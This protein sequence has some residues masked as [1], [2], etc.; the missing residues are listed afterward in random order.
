MPPSRKRKMTASERSSRFKRA[1]SGSL[2]RRNLFPLQRVQLG[3]GPIAPSVFV[4]LRYVAAFTSDGTLFDHVYNLNS[5]FDP[6]RTGTGHQPLGHDQY[7]NFYNRY[8][9]WSTRVKILYQAS[10]AVSSSPAAVGYVADN[11]GSGYGAL[12]NAFEQQGSFQTICNPG[13]PAI[14]IVRNFNLWEIT[15]VSK[16]DY[17]DDRFQAIFGSDPSEVIVYHAMYGQV[18]NGSA[19]VSGHVLA[20]VQLDYNV[21]L[22]DPLSLSSS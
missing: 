5:I 4:R 9:V 1:K 16:A 6:D 14:T 20:R 2:A 10:G 21:E 18:A 17:K 13:G 19:S 7:A 22:Y 8:R 12:D 3:K 11:N 15:G